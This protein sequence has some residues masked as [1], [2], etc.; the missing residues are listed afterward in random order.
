M[1]NTHYRKFIDERLSVYFTA[2]EARCMTCFLQGY[3]YK[4][5][6]KSIG[7]AIG[8]VSFYANNMRRKLSCN[9]NREM[10]VKVKHIDFSQ[11]LVIKKS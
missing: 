3:T 6:A 9:T 11:S 10:M 2:Q 7:I 4:Q 5:A 8:T 1:K